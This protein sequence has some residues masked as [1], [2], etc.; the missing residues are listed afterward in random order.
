QDCDLINDCCCKHYTGHLIKNAYL[1]ELLPEN[2]SGS[3]QNNDLDASG[4]DFSGTLH[5]FAKNKHDFENN[6]RLCNGEMFFITN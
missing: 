4:E 1:S 2:I 5:D 6:V 3:Q